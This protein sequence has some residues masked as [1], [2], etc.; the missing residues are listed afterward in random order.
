MR[1]LLWLSLFLFLSCSAPTGPVVASVNAEG[2]TLQAGDQPKTIPWADINRMQVSGHLLSADDAKSALILTVTI[3]DQQTEVC[4]AYP[5]RV[6]P[7]SFA[8][9]H[10]AISVREADFVKLREA[11]ASA[12]GLQPDPQNE[13]V[14]LK[15]GTPTPAT[16]AAFSHGYGALN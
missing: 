1:H 7:N 10:N 6:D 5:H 8:G 4:S 15:T 12:A 2:L 16:E 11:I 9:I 14:W 3:K 13:G